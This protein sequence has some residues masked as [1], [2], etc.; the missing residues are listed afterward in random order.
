MKGMRV[1]KQEIEER[2]KKKEC[3][4]SLYQLILQ[5]EKMVF[6][7]LDLILYWH[8][9][10]RNAGKLEQAL[11]FILLGARYYP[12]SWSVYYN[13]AVLYEQKEEL[14]QAIECYSKAK[15]IFTITHANA[16]LI[17]DNLPVD[18]KIYQ[19]WDSIL[20][21]LPQDKVSIEKVKDALKWREF[22]CEM[23]GREFFLFQLKKA[24]GEY[25]FCGRN[26]K[27]Y[28]AAKERK[29]S[30][31]QYIDQLGNLGY[32]QGEL[33]EVDEGK[34]MLVSG[35]Q[36]EYLIPIAVAE[37]N[38]LH[39]FLEAQN[40][41]EVLQAEPFH[42][43][44]YRVKN[45]TK[46]ASSGTSYYGKVIPLMHSS[47]RK[48][49]VLNIFVDGLSQ[50]ILNGAN[51][52]KIMPYTYRYF[53]KGSICTEAFST[54]EWTFPSI[55]SHV[56]G[57]DTLHHMMFH[58]KLCTELPYDVPTLAEYFQEQGYLTTKIDGDWRSIPPYGHIRGYKRYIYQNQRWGSKGESIIHDTIEQIEAFKDTDHFL[59]IC[60]GDLHDVAD[61]FDLPVAVQSKLPVSTRVLEEKGATSVKQSASTNKI[62]Q[63]K[64]MAS[65]TDTLLNRL[66]LY[67][68]ENFQDEE[69][70]VSLFADHGQGYLVPE[71]SH[72]ISKE[73]TK[74]AFMFRGGE[75][76]P[77][78]GLTEEIISTVDYVPIMCQMAGIKQRDV[79]IQGRLPVCFGGE[80]SRDYAISE[81]LHPGDTYKVTFY[82]EGYTVYFENGVPVGQ[83]GR[84][85]LQD[86]TI[87]AV[88]MNGKILDNQMLLDEYYQLAVTRIAHLLIY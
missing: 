52:E 1:L 22:S 85:V 60:L 43:N 48:R 86:E 67:L 73:R 45:G 71:E 77:S 53:S 88:D 24:I 55:S 31:Y 57:L 32:S 18:E 56:T 40:I 59:W 69:I 79:E 36:E 41:Y 35:I 70:V 65:Y 23:E 58:D 72:F 11:E 46:I 3:S 84:F 62:Y 61:G 27:R 8:K 29:P 16:M 19:I 34:D 38:T 17:I 82:A 51:F 30:M 66:Y 2:L 54:A 15:M 21:T 28:V 49:L 80:R 76:N 68:G 33:L 47:T 44:Y 10:Y 87:E 4:D 7:D 63:Y 12:A 78:N 39:R 42:F 75:R 64:Q 25:L 5:Y 37:P 14:L 13:M 50:E 9:Y 6:M 20:N 83:D 74:V 26:Q 81:C